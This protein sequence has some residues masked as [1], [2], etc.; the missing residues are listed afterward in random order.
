M[1]SQTG[2]QFEHLKK[3]PKKFQY[4]YFS[5]IAQNICC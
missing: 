1:K 5:T 4:F 2:Y 3:V